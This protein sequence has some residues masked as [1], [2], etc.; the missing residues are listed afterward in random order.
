MPVNPKN[1]ILIFVMMQNSLIALN[2]YFD[3]IYVITIEQAF[4][5]REKLK[6]S[7]EGLD[8]QFLFGADK[9]NFSNDE[10]KQKGIYDEAGA[11]R[12]HRY[13]KV[14][15]PG[16]VAC[17]W[18]HRMVFEDMLAK[19]YEKV[20]V[21]EDDVVPDPDALHL[22]P[23]ILQSIPDDCEFLY[24]GWAKNEEYNFSARMKQVFYHI[25]HSAGFL[26]WS[27]RMIR[28]LFAK[29]H[30]RYF[31]KAGFH[32][33]N[34]AYSLTRLAAEKLIRLQTPIRFIADNL[35]AYAC[36]EEIIKGYITIP[37]VFI[38][39]KLPD[40]THSDSYIR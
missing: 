28:N 7:L 4:H 27:H 16:E 3:H 35:T 12:L 1:E 31:K 23:E 10:L 5:R 36:T 20:L 19:G 18:S 37:P 38:H 40:G 30:S 14:M 13:G 25:L 22:I 2:Q 39:E 11:I 33:Y 24:W 32:D 8:Y 29:P 6:K 34:N 9:A 21:F 26:K 17:A 15:K